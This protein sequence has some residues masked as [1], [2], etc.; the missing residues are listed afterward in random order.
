MFQITFQAIIWN[1]IRLYQYVYAFSVDFDS[2][3][4]AVILD[5]QRY[6]MKKYDIKQCLNLLRNVYW[7]IKRL[8]NRNFLWAIRLWLQGRLKYVSLNNRTCQ[9]RPEL[10]KQTLIKF[11][12]YSFTASVNKCRGSCNAIDDPYGLV[13]FPN[14]VKNMNLRV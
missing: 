4:V 10:A 9:A 12:F 3:D 7:I 14:K 5:T 8:Y 11:F 6:L 1:K 13:Y 2:I